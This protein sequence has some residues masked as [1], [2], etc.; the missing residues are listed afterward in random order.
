V[1]FL[2]RWRDQLFALLTARHARDRLPAAA[3]GD[4]VDSG[5]RGT[6]ACV[7]VDVRPEAHAV[8]YRTGDSRR[9]P[10]ILRLIR[11]WPS[12]RSCSTRSTPRGGLRESLFGADPAAEVLAVPGQGRTVGFACSSATTPPSAAAAAFTWRLF[13]E[14]AWRG[15][16][17]GK[18]LLK[19]VAR[20]AVERG[21]PRFEWAVLDWNTPAHRVLSQLRGPAAGR[22]DDLPPDRRCL[23]GLRRTTDSDESE[24][25]GDRGGFPGGL[26]GAR[27]APDPAAAL[28]ARIDQL[29]D[30]G[31]AE[32]IAN[33]RHLHQHPELSNREFETEKFIVKQLKAL[34]YECIRASPAPAWSRAQGRQ[35]GRWW[36]CV[37]TWTRC[38]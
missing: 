34:G 29:A 17:Y 33:R 16:G 9:H 32:V 3:A 19:A 24:R 5:A 22:L 25:G 27:E 6:G 11:G 10:D 4:V 12:T 36:R 37:R 2:L 1:P 38:R 23:R 13:V 31:E 20:I 8:R 30:A 15:R 18:A 14:P 26:V 28:H 7:R 21:C 35:P